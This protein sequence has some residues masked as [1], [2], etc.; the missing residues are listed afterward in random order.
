M[1][2][3]IIIALLAS[4]GYFIFVGFASNRGARF[5]FLP[6]IRTEDAV[7]NADEFSATTVATTVS[8]AT[9]VLAYF[10]LA[11]YFGLFIV[12]TAVTTGLGM[13]L[14]SAYAT[15]IWKKLSV[16]SKSPTLSEFLGTEYDSV[17]VTKISAACISVGVLMILATELLVG[18][19]YIAST[20]NQ[21]RPWVIP[22]G[23]SLVA[24]IYTMQGGF[25][26]VVV[27][28][29]IQMRAI[30]IFSL[31]VLL[32]LA[33][34]AY[35]PSHLSG[36]VRERHLLKPVPG[37]WIF[38]IGVTVM[39]IPTHISNIAMW[40]R[41]GAANETGIISRGLSR[42]TWQIVLAWALI[43]LAACLSV[44]LIGV[45][46]GV[47]PFSSLLEAMFKSSA[48]PVLVFVVVVG[49][50]SAM[51]S[52]AS[53]NLIAATHTVSVDLVGASNSLPRQRATLIVLAVG[54]VAIVEGLDKIGFSI[55]DLV[56]AIYGGALTLFPLILATLHLRRQRLNRM[57][58]EASF[59]VVAGFLLAWSAAFYGKLGEMPNL[60][61][62]SPTIGIGASLM[63]VALGVYRTRHY[64]PDEGSA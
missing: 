9:I 8:L 52:T 46:P 7:K 29:Q 4:S 28:D 15:R 31:L 54:S 6:M 5:H 53:T 24:V 38:L 62:L 60:V 16:Y 25:R 61:F 34:Y 13:A 48:G 23:L 50:Y 36:A 19:K 27:T 40:Q 44:F 37:L 18:S 33:A 11:S 14:V 47:Q 1:S 58:R 39:N 30:W 43:A 10:E 55:A 42:S 20:V 12:W 41:I 56:F 26:A 2:T 51:L 57:S 64:L 59:A 32:F 21:V 63:F 35:T 49:I 17:W 22:A 45:Q 3:T